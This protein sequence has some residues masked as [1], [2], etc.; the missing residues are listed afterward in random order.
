MIDL[1]THS[2][3]SD[4]SLSPA[5]LVA[6]AAST[7]LSAI[8]L[9][10]HDTVDGLDEARE[11]CRV[12][13]I[14][15]VPGIELEIDHQPGV[16]HLLGLGLTCWSGELRRKLERVREYR[17]ARNLRMVANLQR[18]GIDID[19]SELLERAGHETV[20]RPHFAAELAQKG[21][22]ATVQE[23]FDRYIGD[24]KP[25]YE[26][27]EALTVGRACA[28]L[29]EAGAKAIIA[30]PHTLQLGW[31]ELRRSL[32]RWK[33]EGVDGLEA[34]NPNVSINDGHRLAAL[35]EEFGL[36]VTAGS[37][38]HG[39]GQGDRRLGYSSDGQ[40]IDARFLEPFAEAA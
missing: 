14:T 1:H 3:A 11:A 20:G 39:P 25:Y 35:A 37:D 30:H 29:H 13:G 5:E 2:T 23:A 27:K 31:A 22:V 26:R 40:P 24:G 10:D 4:G 19:Y 6:L 33:H 32:H 9:T 21:V 8:A 28:T 12:H 34:Y 15:F 18:A 36:I 38:F 16:F 7:G 17:T